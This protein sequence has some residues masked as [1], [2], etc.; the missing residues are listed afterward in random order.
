MR[1][2]ACAPS[3]GFSSSRDVGR[4]KRVERNEQLL[5]ALGVDRDRSR[6]PLFQVVF[7]YVTRDRDTRVPTTEP[8]DLAEGADSLLA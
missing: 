7:N 4:G 8:E 6:S 1:A 3:T 2:R 5:D